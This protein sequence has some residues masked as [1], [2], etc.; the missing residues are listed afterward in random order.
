[1]SRLQDPP[2]GT[3]VRVDFQSKDQREGI[4]VD[5]SWSGHAAAELTEN[6]CSFGISQ[7]FHFNNLY[8]VKKKIKRNK[9]CH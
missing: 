8:L 6:P 5:F 2:E 1:M 7:G 9:L 3:H 4:Q